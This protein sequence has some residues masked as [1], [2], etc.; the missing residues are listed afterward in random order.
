MKTTT[1]NFVK[2]L[3]YGAVVM[4]APLSAFAAVDLTPITSIMTDIALV[5]TAIFAVFVA[6]KGI[7]LIR[8]AL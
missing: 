7:K 1:S 4:A 2:K 5:G 3:G 8:R 6:I